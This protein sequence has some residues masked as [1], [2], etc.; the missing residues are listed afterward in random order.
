MAYF[1]IL[2]PLGLILILSKTFA[3]LCGRL[4]LPAVVGL[5]LAGIAIGCI[6]FIP[7]QSVLSATTMEGLGFLAKIGVVLIMFSAGLETDLRQIKKVGLP[8][9]VITMLGVLVPMGLGFLVAMLFN[10]GVGALADNDT[11]LSNIFYGV[12]LTATSVSVSVATL[13]DLGHLS[14][15]AGTTIVTA[16][17]LDDIIG[18]VVLSFVTAM[19]GGGNGVDAPSPVIVVIK[20][21]LFF[22]FVIVVGLIANKIFMA[23][24]RRFPHHRLMAVYGVGFCFLMAYISEAVFGVADIT[25]AFAAGLFLS[26]NP[27]AG[28]IDRKSDEMGYLIFTPVFFCNI[29]ISTDLTGI[30]VGVVLFGVVFIVAGLVGKLGG[31]FAASKLFGYSNKEAAVVG[32]GMMVRAEVALVCAQK[33][34]EYGLVSADIMPF[35]VILILVSSLIAPIVM[36]K[37]LDRE[38]PA[39]HAK[40]PSEASAAP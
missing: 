14:G 22:V 35:I 20:T 13:R 16:A 38:P 6:R 2:L 31:C 5:L 7:G 33:G 17:I 11:L 36:K 24:D 18:V 39:D 12:I 8:V 15:K 34:M 37:L 1:S 10:G 40:A 3:K 23:L 19:K 4:R 27:D 30:G 9:L 21:C 29:G 28:Y 32:L 25:G 26:R